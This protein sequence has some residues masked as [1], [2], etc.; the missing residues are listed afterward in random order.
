MQSRVSCIPW[1]PGCGGDMPPSVLVPTWNQ[2]LAWVLSLEGEGR[3]CSQDVTSEALSHHLI[4][5]TTL[6]TTTKNTGEDHRPTSP[7]ETGAQDRGSDQTGAW[8]L[9]GC[10]ADP[11]G[12]T[13]SLS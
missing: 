3:L 8:T 9:V 11:L 2:Q 10:G 4:L 12:L 5:L 7:K 13:P 1:L 6:K